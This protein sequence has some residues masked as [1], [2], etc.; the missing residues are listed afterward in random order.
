[1][2]VD[3]VRKH[4]T[5]VAVTYSDGSAD[6]RSYRVSFEK[7][8]ERL[9]FRSHHTVQDYLTRLT[10]AVQAGIFP[11]VGDNRRFGNYRVATP[12]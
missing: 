7:I 8:A 1:M 4:L 2:I 12:R 10:P 3:E 9:G 6:P 5:Q 11:D